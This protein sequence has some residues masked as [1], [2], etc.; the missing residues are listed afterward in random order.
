MLIYSQFDISDLLSFKLTSL[1]ILGDSG[2]SY[3]TKFT[4]NL[5]LNQ[6]YFLVLFPFSNF[7]S[8]STYSKK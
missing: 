8:I 7:K 2:Q 3:L 5:N 1:G 4:Y 6:G